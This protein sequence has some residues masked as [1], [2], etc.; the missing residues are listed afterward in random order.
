MKYFI[1]NMCRKALI[2]TTLILI[3]I[4]SDKTYAKGITVSNLTDFKSAVIEN[5][6]NRKTSFVITY[7]GDNQEFFEMAGTAIDEAVISD[8]YLRWSWRRVSHRLARTLGVTTATIKVEYITTKDQEAA[9]ENKVDEILSQIITSDMS[10]KAMVE[11]IHNYIV[12]NVAYDYSLT[13]R[14]AYTALSEGLTVCQGYALLLD[15]ML[16][17]V[18]IQSEIVTGDIPSG[19]HAWN[20]VNVDGKWYHIDSTNNDTNSSKVFY[21]VTDQVLMSYNF[22]WERSKFPAAV[23]TYIPEDSG[24]VEASKLR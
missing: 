4:P 10:E 13:R 17:K 21:M 9:I 20:L 2:T 24:I 1:K 15:K 8:D 16:H 11:A 7:T 23:T 22:S 19:L 14:S 6:V 18:G 5:M 12:S 3:V